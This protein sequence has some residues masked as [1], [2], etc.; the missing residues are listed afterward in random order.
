VRARHRRRVHLS[1]A[2]AWLG[3]GAVLSWVFAHSL[4][5]IVGMSWF[6]CWYAAISA[7][8]AETPVEDEDKADRRGDG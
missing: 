6:A 7:W 5:W 2:L 3:P 1:V 8:A 4:A